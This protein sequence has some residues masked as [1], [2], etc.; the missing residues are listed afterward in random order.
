MEFQFT[1]ELQQAIAQNPAAFAKDPTTAPEILAALATCHIDQT[2][3]IDRPADVRQIIAQNPN[4]PIST[5]LN[6]IIDFPSEVAENAAFTLAQL[7]TPDLLFTI[8]PDTLITIF[9][10]ERAPKRLI[11]HAIQHREE[12]VIKALLENYPIA[13]LELE[14]LI[15]RFQHHHFYKSDRENIAKRVVYHPKLSE[16]LKRTIATG[17]NIDLKQ[18][19]VIRCLTARRNLPVD[20][21]KLLID[22]A[23][24]CFQNNSNGHPP[25]PTDITGSIARWIQT[26]IAKSPEITDELADYLIRDDQPYLQLSL[27]EYF[28]FGKLSEKVQLRIAQTQV[29]DYD[30][31]LTIQKNIASTACVQSVVNILAEHPDPEVRSIIA[32]RYN[33]K[34]AMILHLARDQSDF[35]Q[36]QLAKNCSIDQAC[37]AAMAQSSEARV[38]EL[39]A[40]HVNT[41]EATLH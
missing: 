33:L 3:P 23:Y 37:L 24:T 14:C 26:T 12:D 6:L 5:L 40:L 19:L 1:P 10:G 39:V 27:T 7:E 36:A 35:V 20:L 11:D 30:L 38:L 18:E 25:E 15:S 34:P 9:R 21:I 32:Q 17:E 2:A 8:K 4:T 16:P 22:D 41:P 28:L 31:R 13:E 29:A